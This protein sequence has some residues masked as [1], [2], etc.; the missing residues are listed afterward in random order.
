MGLTVIVL[1]ALFLVYSIMLIGYD[2]ASDGSPAWQLAV[3]WP[4]TPVMT[5]IG[6]WKN[7]F[8][9][10]GYEDDAW[11]ACTVTYLIIAA[12]ALTCAGHFHSKGLGVREED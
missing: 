11:L 8:P 10:L 7:S 6:E 2:R 3:L 4:V 5:A 1:I 9:K 12:I